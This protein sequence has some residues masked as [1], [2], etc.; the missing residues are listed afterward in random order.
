L[1][2]G[3][4]QR[5]QHFV[6]DL[7]DK[8]QYEILK[9]KISEASINF[10]GVINCSGILHDEEHMP[11]KQLSDINLLWLQESININLFSH[12]QLAKLMESQLSTRRFFWVSLSAMVGSIG[13]NQLGG[14]YSYRISK[15]ALN[16]F[17]KGLSIEWKRKNRDNCIIA[18]HPGTTKSPM[19]KPFKV[20]PDKLYSPKKSAERIYQLISDLRSHHNGSFLNWNGETIPW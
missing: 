20:R 17:I 15:S 4:Q 7:F 10:S 12:V 2:R 3:K 16:M 18:L 5:K 14:W 11:E 19:T 6:A 13:D 8:S 1:S 9:K